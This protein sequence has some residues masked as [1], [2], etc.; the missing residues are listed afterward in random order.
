MSLE[1]E[2]DIAN[3]IL[4]AD[5]FEANRLVVTQNPA[6]ILEGQVQNQDGVMHVNADRIE[7]LRSTNLPEQTS[8]DFH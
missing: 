3:A 7:A 8:H 1:D 2:S 4:D 6:L 5:V